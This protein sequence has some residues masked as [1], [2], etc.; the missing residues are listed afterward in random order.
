MLCVKSKSI[1]H[2]K[3][4]PG[5][6][7]LDLINFGSTLIQSEKYQPAVL[8]NNG[9]TSLGFVIILEEGG[10]GQQI[11]ASP[12]QVLDEIPRTLCNLITASPN[13]VLDEIP[14]TLC[15]L[16]TASPNQVLDEI[17]HTLCNLITA[18]PNQVLESVTHSYCV[19]DTL[20]MYSNCILYTLIV[21]FVR[22]L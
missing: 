6:K 17:P 2:L 20:V 8:Y 13:Q 4:P 3:L 10:I 16:I 9:P 12:N 19:I 18:S 21:F 7:Q 11:T 22:V 15:N 1:T 14:H 5:T